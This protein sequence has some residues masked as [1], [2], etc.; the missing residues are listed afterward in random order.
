MIVL[1]VYVADLKVEL[2]FTNVKSPDPVLMTCSYDRLALPKQVVWYREI[3]GITLL[4]WTSRGNSTHPTYNQASDGLAEKYV[5]AEQT[6][7]LINHQ[8][9]LLHSISSDIGSYYCVVNVTEV[10][11]TSP[12]KQLYVSGEWLSCNCEC[13]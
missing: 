1:L 8:I 12:P 7:Y 9:W 13:K 6:T 10:P 11:Y 2:H 4:I 3:M 5:Y